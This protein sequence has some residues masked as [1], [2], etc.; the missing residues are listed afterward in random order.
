MSLHR[1]QIFGLAAVLAFASGATSSD[2]SAG[3][4][5]PCND[6]VTFLSADN[7]VP[8]N[9]QGHE[10]RFRFTNAASVTTTS[11]ATCSS[12]LKITCT[13]VTPTSVTLAAGASTT[14]IATFNAGAHGFGF[15]TVYSC[16][17]SATS[18]KIFVN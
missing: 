16:S 7:P 15:I 13:G 6:P 11:S 1:P 9:T 18:N 2:P 8:A 12:T 10:A 3:E 17:A 14:V 4:R 5:V